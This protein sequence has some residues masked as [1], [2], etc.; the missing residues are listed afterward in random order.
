MLWE[1]GS[2]S[3]SFEKLEGLFIFSKAIDPP[4]A[5]TELKPPNAIDLWEKHLVLSIISVDPLTPTP[6]LSFHGC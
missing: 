5:S 4:H 6:Y 3:I 1:K 2:F